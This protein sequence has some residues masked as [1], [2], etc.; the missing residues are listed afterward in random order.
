MIKN[1]IFDFGKV[2]VQFEPE[3]MTSRFIDDKDDIELVSKVLFDRLYWDRLDEGTISDK[4]VI[5]ESCKRLPLRLHKAAEDIYNNWVYNLPEICGMREL[6]QKL[7]SN[8]IRLFLL[9]NISKN[10]AEKS[11]DISILSYFEK[12]IFSA[13]CGYTKPSLEIFNHL[14]EQCDI[15][16]EE[17]IFIDDSQINIDGAKK[18]GL[19]TYLFDGDSKKLEAFLITNKIL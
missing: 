18:A 12:C 9:S 19:S 5:E 4:Q 6:L 7:K 17:S 3:Y 13:V 8:G 2:L 14:F 11:G 1:V 16:A 15:K 10:F